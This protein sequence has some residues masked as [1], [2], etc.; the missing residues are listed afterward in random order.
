MRKNEGGKTSLL[1]NLQV[2]KTSRMIRQ[3]F[4][5]LSKMSNVWTRSGFV[6]KAGDMSS[7]IIKRYVDS[8]RERY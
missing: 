8:R 5:H 4:E 3:E 6:S 7:K 1:Y 2:G